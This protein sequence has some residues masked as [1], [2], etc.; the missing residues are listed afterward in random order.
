MDT[1]ITSWLGYIVAAITGLSTIFLYRKQERQKR[2]LEN[3]AQS[4]KNES[5]SN[6][7]WRRIVEERNTE[8]KRLNEKL[9]TIRSHYE[10]EISSL[11]TRLQQSL[12]NDAQCAMY[13]GLYH[14]SRCDNFSCPSRN[15]PLK[16]SLIDKY[17][18]L[19]PA[20]ARSCTSCQSTN[21]EQ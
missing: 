12:E 10:T 1:I 9:E 7:E 19:T 21:Q 17:C 16:D 2:D 15:P 8:C 13:I 6:D 4:I 18:S 11:R 20:S 14:S 3:M 5:T